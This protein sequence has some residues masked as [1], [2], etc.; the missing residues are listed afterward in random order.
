MRPRPRRGGELGG[1]ARTHV[2]LRVEGLD[3]GLTHGDVLEAVKHAAHVEHGHGAD[4]D[5]DLDGKLD[6]LRQL[7]AVQL[8]LDPQRALRG[9][10]RADLDVIVLGPQDWRTRGGVSA[11]AGAAQPGAGG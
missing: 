5:A 9:P 2:A 11:A 10:T 4:P 6:A 3:Q 8:Q 7:R 1:E